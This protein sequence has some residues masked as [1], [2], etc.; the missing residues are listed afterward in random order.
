MRV[1]ALLTGTVG[2]GK[3]AI[4]ERI[5]NDQFDSKYFVTIGRKSATKQLLLNN[6]N[7][8]VVFLDC[9]GEVLQNKVPNLS[10]VGQDLILYIVDLSR[11]T[12]FKNIKKDL[13]FF[14]QNYPEIRVKILLNKS[15]LFEADQLEA[16]LQKLDMVSFHGVI[17][18]K[19]G[20]NIMKL[21]ESFILEILQG[22]SM[23]NQTRGA[24]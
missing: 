10:F 14:E 23:T 24:A 17:S 20:A 3:S 11:Q 15:D 6:E 16:V 18:A 5:I 19:S 1:N 12:S 8:D 21:L 9:Q 4:I 7:V 22:K 13:D 2:S